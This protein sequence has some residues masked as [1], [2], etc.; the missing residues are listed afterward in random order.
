MIDPIM[1]E[2]DLISLIPIIKG[3]GGIITDYYGN[4]PLESDSIV[5]ATQELHSEVIKILNK[6]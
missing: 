5:A 3:S 6:F 4:D 2:W 1:N